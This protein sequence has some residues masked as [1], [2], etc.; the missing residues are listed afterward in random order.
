MLTS[1]MKVVNPEQITTLLLDPAY[2]PFGIATARAAFYS[3][4][5]GKGT[6]IDANGVPYKWDRYISRNISVLPDQ[7][8][9]RSGFNASYKDNIWVIPT[10]F[11]A[12]EDFFF[13]RKKLLK[14]RKENKD[15]QVALPPL[16]EVYDY[17]DGK[18][19]FCYTKIKL[20]EASREHI[21]S[22]A[23]GGKNH[24]DNIALACKSCNSR[25]GHAMPKLDIFGK[26]IE[27]KM[28]IRPVH[29]TLPPNVT[30]RHEWAEY[31]M[32]AMAAA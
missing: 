29:Y 21:H 4:L 7:P 11:V 19:C 1:E 15:G 14:E 31:L 30:P 5:K 24:E 16:R 23:F 6:G 18:C 28:K 3:L 9:M 10:I 25:A 13:K 2:M 26:P 17:Y 27:A 12:N 8:F 22:K 32:G 20:S